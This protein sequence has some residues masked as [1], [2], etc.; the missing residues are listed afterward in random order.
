MATAA[1]GGTI[2]RVAIAS[3]AASTH[4]VT[5]AR[6]SGVDNVFH[7]GTVFGVGVGV[8]FVRSFGSARARWREREMD[9]SRSDR[10]VRMDD[11]WMKRGVDVWWRRE[12]EDTLRVD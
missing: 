8:A 3:I 4:G 11:G 5:R 10:D 6:E 7:H 9:G 12:G 2:G 1:G